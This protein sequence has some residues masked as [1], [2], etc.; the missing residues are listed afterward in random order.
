M[1]E[2]QH[3]LNFAVTHQLAVGA[4]ILFMKSIYLLHTHFSFLSHT[5]YLNGVE[6]TKLIW[7]MLVLESCQRAFR[8]VLMMLRRLGRPSR[9]SK[10]RITLIYS[11]LLCIYTL[12]IFLKKN[13][14]QY[15]LKVWKATSATEVSLHTSVTE[16]SQHMMPIG[17]AWALSYYHKQNN[18]IFNVCSVI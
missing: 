16:I 2:C 18:G 14:L 17:S 13:W 3:T 12:C 5:T 10:V 11:Y 9:A 7:E 15:K 6:A 4:Q 1:H 8:R